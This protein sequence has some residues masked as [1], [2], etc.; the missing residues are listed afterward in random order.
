MADKNIQKIEQTPPASNIVTPVQLLQIAVSQN[1]DLD[2]LEKLMELQKQWES[3]EAKKAYHTAVAAFK[4]ESILIIKNKSVS[5]KNNDNTTTSYDHA[6]LD[7]VVEVIAPLLAKYGLTHSWSVS[8]GEGGRI[9]VKCFLTHASGHSENVELTASPDDTGKKNNIQR[10]ASTINYLERYTLLAITGLAAR[11]QDD[12]GAAS[13]D[14]THDKEAYKN[15]FM[16][17]IEYGMNCYKL[18]ERIEAIK[19]YIAD[20]DNYSA[21]YEYY[22]MSNAE[23]MSIKLAPTKGGI[24]TIDEKKIIDN[25]SDDWKAGMQQAIK[26]F[27]D[28]DR[29]L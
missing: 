24:F 16:K 23:M 10:I 22:Q 5:F 28:I 21:G 12:D 18:K 19:D 20:G 14:R 6:S 29:S 25:P 2:K 26:D 9:T 11:G 7:H 8:Q 1:S 15:G 13:G 27:P 3:N 17:G 4:T